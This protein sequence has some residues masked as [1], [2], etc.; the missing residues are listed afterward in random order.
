M[1]MVCW[2][3]YA[4]FWVGVGW[5]GVLLEFSDALG[6]CPFGVEAYRYS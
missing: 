1:Y 2:V 4:K 3:A 5:G 6:L